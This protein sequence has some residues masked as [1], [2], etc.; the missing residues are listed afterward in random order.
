MY[1]FN[2]HK[3]KAWMAF[4]TTGGTEYK[5]EYGGLSMEYGGLKY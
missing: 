5:R 2:S 1:T 3:Q 4:Y